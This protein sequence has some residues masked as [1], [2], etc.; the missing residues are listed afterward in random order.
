[1]SDSFTIPSST[2]LVDVKAI[3]GG[4]LVPPSFIF[5]KPVLP[6]HETFQG[7]TYSFLLENKTKGK[8]VL[9][10]LGLRKD[11]EGWSPA[12]QELAKA[13]GLSVDKDVPTQLTE[14]GVH[15]DS[16][17]A[18]IWRYFLFSHVSDSH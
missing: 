15:L 13:F 7:I 12:I 3:D 6:G 9:F 18:V 1:M 16:V 11:S 8:R 4:H 14:G 2:A 10:D 5:W 17:D